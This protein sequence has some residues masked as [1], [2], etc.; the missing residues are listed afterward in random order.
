[1]TDPMSPDAS[2]G[3]V[4]K[5]SGVR[6]VNNMPVYILVGAVAAFLLVMVLVASDR[7]ANQNKPAEKKKEEKTATTA[8]LAKELAGD[9]KDGIVQPAVI[10]PLVIPAEFPAAAA[11]A[12]APKLGSVPV[13]RPTNLDA[14]PLPAGGMPGQL[15]PPVQQLERTPHDDETDRIR[16]AKLRQFEEAVKARPSVPVTSPKTTLPTPL[17]KDETLSRLSAIRQQMEANVLGDPTDAYKAKLIQIQASGLGSAGGGSASPASP[18]TSRLMQLGGEGGAR[19]EPLRNLGSG[20]ADRW[21]LDAK[22]EAPRT[23][24]ELRAGFVIP[25]LMVSGINSDLPGQVIAQV[26]QDVFDTPTGRYKLIPQGSRL[27]G[28][29][30]SEVAFG[31]SR[32]FVSWQR[33]IFPDG[34]A[35]DIGAMQGADSAGYAGFSDQVNNHY[36]RLF[37]SAFLLSGVTAGVSLSQPKSNSSSDS[38]QTVSGAMSEALGQQLGQVTA[39]LISKNMTIAP[40]LEIRPG[41]RFNVMVT[42]DLTFPKPFQAFDY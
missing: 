41:Y 17:S 25:A 34:K 36:L 23:P 42:K 1:M 21:R 3:Q 22:P 18:T 39:Q 11:A 37:G 15:R 16:A 19:A 14:P 24:Y 6:R 2:P 28:N 40:T 26:S 12:S 38:Q 29:Y 20:Q 30:T 7:S 33:I 9:Q 31:Q 35:L 5:K 8:M 32:L 10:A 13:T 27:I 4:L